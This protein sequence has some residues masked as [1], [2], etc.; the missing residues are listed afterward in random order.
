M[1]FLNLPRPFNRAS[2]LNAPHHRMR[3]DQITGALRLRAAVDQ[4]LRIDSSPQIA[5]D[6]LQLHERP[7]QL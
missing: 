5:A 3:L 1:E 4:Q 7:S 6:K 2:S